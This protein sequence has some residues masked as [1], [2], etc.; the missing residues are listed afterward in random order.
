VRR[1]ED[2]LDL[3]LEHTIAI[4]ANI[5]TLPAN[6]LREC[7]KLSTLTGRPR[8]CFVAYNRFIGYKFGTQLDYYTILGN[9]IHFKEAAAASFTGNIVLNVPSIPNV[10]RIEF[11]PS[12]VDAG[13]ETITFQEAHPWQTG[14]EVYISSTVTAPSATGLGTPILPTTK[15]YLIRLSSTAVQL[16]TSLANAHVGTADNITAT[17]SGRLTMASSI[18]ATD[19]VI[20]NLIVLLAAVMTG[21]IKVA[22]MLAA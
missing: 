16:A 14:D 18:A 15:A 17:G 3:N 9:K 5:G 1:N 8:A 10:N 7:M 19:S 4:A 12:D 11:A 2:V 13:A 6:V 22:E 20:E 21:E